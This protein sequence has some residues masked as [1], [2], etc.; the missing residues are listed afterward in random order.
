VGPGGHRRR[1]RLADEMIELASAMTGS[2][3]LD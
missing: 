2:G 3:N 1:R